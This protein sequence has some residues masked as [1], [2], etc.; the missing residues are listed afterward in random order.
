MKDWSMTKKIVVLVIVIIVILAIYNYKTIAHKLGISNTR[1]Y[2]E[3]GMTG[4]E[5]INPTVPSALSDSDPNAG[6]PHPFPNFRNVVVTPY[7]YN[8]CPDFSTRKAENR[9]IGGLNNIYFPDTDGIFSNGCPSCIIY[10]SVTYYYNG[11]DGKGCYYQVNYN[12]VYPVFYNYYNFSR[13]HH[14]GHGG[15]GGP[16][17]GIGPGTEPGT[18][19]GGGHGH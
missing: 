16:G 10:N 7:Y 11:Y 12:Y 1:M 9:M 15:S 17:S 8:Q 13:G 2:A 6:H 5:I 4:S 14:G 19:G 3:G 18:G